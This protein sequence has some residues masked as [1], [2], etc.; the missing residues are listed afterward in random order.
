MVF[1][2]AETGVPDW[3]SRI[4][5]VTHEQQLSLRQGAHPDPLFCSHQVIGTARVQSQILFEEAE[6]VLNGLITNDCATIT[7]L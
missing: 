4:D 5:Q 2:I 1:S 6:Q 7:A 3:A